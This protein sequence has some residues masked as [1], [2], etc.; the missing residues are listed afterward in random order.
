HGK[1]VIPLSF[2]YISTVGATMLL[3]YAIYRRDPVFIMG[4]GSGLF[5]YLR[6]LA[7]V[8]KQ[9]GAGEDVFAGM[10]AVLICG[11]LLFFNLG[12]R[13]LWSSGEGRIAQIARTMRSSG[14][15]VVPRFQD[16][17]DPAILNETLTKP[18]LYHWTTT[19]TQ[20][21]LGETDLA[22]RL[23]SAFAGLACVV[24]VYVLARKVFSSTAAFMAVLVLG[25]NMG[26]WWASRTA[27]LD[28][29]LALWISLAMALFYFG[30]ASP[31]RRR[32]Y[33]TA[34]WA[35]VALGVITKGPGALAFPVVTLGVVL[36]MR[37]DAR[38]L[39]SFVPWQGV[40]L[41]LLVA[42]PWHAMMI[43]RVP[44]K[45]AR[46]YFFG[47]AA[48]WFGTD[49]G[50]D[51]AEPVEPTPTAGDALEKLTD[52]FK[53]LGYLLLNFFPW[54]FFIPI[55]L[56]AWWRGPHR[57]GDPGWMWLVV[58]LV[59]GLVVLSLVSTKSNRYIVPLY[60]AAAMLVAGVWHRFEVYRRG[61]TRSIVVLLVFMA[62]VL[63]LVLTIAHLPDQAAVR[64]AERI[65]HNRQDRVSLTF[66][67]TEVFVGGSVGLY[68]VAEAM[69]ACGVGCL[70]F[71]R[72]QRVKAS[73]AC[74]VAV[75]VVP[76]VVFVAF[77][78]PRVDERRTPVPL[79]RHTRMVVPEEAQLVLCGRAQPYW[80]YYLE[81]PV[82][83]V[84]LGKVRHTLERD[85]P[86]Y[87]LLW[88]GNLEHL[89]KV[90]P[91]WTA[92]RTVVLLTDE[93]DEQQLVLLANRP[94][95]EA[96][97]ARCMQRV[98]GRL[99]ALRRQVDEQAEGV[100]NQVDRLQALE[101]TGRLPGLED[102]STRAVIRALI[103]WSRR[104]D[105]VNYRQ[106]GDPA[107][108]PSDEPSTR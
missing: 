85:E 13:A 39:R 70:V 8:H 29:M 93:V 89:H 31:A 28:A 103:D 74:L 51:A 25:T 7:L 77:I 84:A 102:D 19:V 87:A 54:S 37:K 30:W 73:F 56:L 40:L 76:M 80:R 23:P 36:L 66:Y 34:A 59:A 81:R 105:E 108:T 33:V 45:N 57:R 67:F 4:Q 43:N 52:P 15:Y 83:V 35:A 22:A 49:A 86:A 71:A 98:A 18:P 97:R 17:L 5:I 38:P 95:A 78:L 94:G 106:G 14:D 24:V 65:G 90:L 64:L 12:G 20:R 26:F 75:F 11:F 72:R 96:A 27:R 41:F 50:G 63:A 60:P 88:P 58:W 42:V 92:E 3:M 48:G 107:M 79:T 55:A 1:S 44:A 10:L 6:N 21:M 47:Q 100:A 101:R 104:L 2:W 99:A 32:W 62:L 53:Y 91:G 82:E 61:L 69:V 9:R 16:Q 46:Y 68:A